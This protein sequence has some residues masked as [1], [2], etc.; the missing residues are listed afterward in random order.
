MTTAK[1][2]HKR[3]AELG[4]KPSPETTLTIVTDDHN[5]HCLTEAD[6]D[7]WWHSLKPHEKADVYE[8]DL[9]QVEPDYVG[10][11]LYEKAN[12]EVGHAQG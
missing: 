8:R 7:T 5:V 3:M 12:Q 9:E 1:R 11:L 4:T 10:R 6:L 2:L